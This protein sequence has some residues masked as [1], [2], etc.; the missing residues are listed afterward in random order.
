MKL[1]KAEN[2][3]GKKGKYLRYLVYQ[4]LISKIPITTKSLTICFYNLPLSALQ[5]DHFF[6]QQIAPI[7]HWVHFRIIISN[8]SIIDFNSLQFSLQVTFSILQNAVSFS[9]SFPCLQLLQF[10]KN[11]KLCTLSLLCPL[12]SYLFVLCYLF[13]IYL[14]LSYL[15]LTLHLANNDHLN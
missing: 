4:I 14:F 13:V 1:S 10:Y 5:L 12:N 11:V 8:I 2:N 9:S 7:G 3:H 15:C 6:H